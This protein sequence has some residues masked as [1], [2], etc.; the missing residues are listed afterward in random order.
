MGNPWFLRILALALAILLFV[1]VKSDI[2]NTNMNASGTNVDVLRDVPLELYYD[3]DNLVVSGVPET[4]TVN[5]EG[6]SN[7]VLSAKIMKDYKVFVDLRELSIGQHRVAISNENFSDKLKVRIDPVY[8]NVTIEEKISQEFRVDP[9]MNESLLAENYIVKSYDVEP[10]V[11]TITGAK[12]VV[13]SIAYVKATIEQEQGINKSF[14]KDARVR[15]LDK[16]LNKLDVSVEPKTVQVKVRVEEYSKEVPVALVEK[17]IPKEG[18]TINKLS[19]NTQTIRLYGPRAIIDKIEELKVD[20]DISKIEDSGDFEVKL[21]VPD[22][23]TKLSVDKIR[24]IGDVTP[25]PI[26]ETPIEEDVASGISERSFSNVAVE[27]RGLPSHLE[28]TF[29]SP[30]DGMVSVTAKGAP[31][32]LDTISASDIALYVE[33]QNAKVGENTFPIKM[34]ASTSSEIDWEM[35]VSEVN[36]FIK[37]V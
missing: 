6:P 24:V 37:E 2:E 16:D 14:E 9:D 11:V 36:L 17:G 29:Q 26:T 27:V 3:D 30:T 21:T 1:Y 22:G 7:L 35:S 34:D 15:V 4:V 31:E 20:V 13:N 19:T 33:A 5:I 25:A 18:V 10:K 8:V 23:V 28:G 12:S 32:A